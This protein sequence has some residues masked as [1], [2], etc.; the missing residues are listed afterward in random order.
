MLKTHT[1][2]AY[3]LLLAMALQIA[4]TGSI[5]ETSVPAAENQIKALIAKTYDK[6]NHKVETAPVVVS[7][8]YAIA[9]WIQAKNG[10]RALLRKKQG[11]WEILACGGDGFKDANVLKDAGIPAPAS[12][13]L[14]AKLKVAEQ[15]LSPDRVRQFG[16]YGTPAATDHHHHH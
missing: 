16:L 6:P 10:G 12:K 11:Q 14:L 8:D 9:D 13:D 4:S 15:S 7:G 5:A 1:Q 3:G 2:K